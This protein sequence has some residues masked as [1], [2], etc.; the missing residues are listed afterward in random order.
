MIAENLTERQADVLNA[1][2]EYIDAFGYGPSYRDIA[3]QTRLSVERVR[4]HV[5]RLELLGH[6]V[7]ESATARSVRLATHPQ[8]GLQ[9]NR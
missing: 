4:Q 7:R 5:D 8:E 1:I 2:G 9:K 3:A 6:I